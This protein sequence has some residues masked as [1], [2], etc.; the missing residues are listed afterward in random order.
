MTAGR[1]AAAA[2]LALSLLLP[3]GNGAAEL[4]DR[5]VASVN[6]DV[7]ALSDLRRAVAFNQALGARGSGR[8]LAVEVLEGLINRSLLRQEAARL[9]FV[10]VTDE[11]ASAETA[12]LRARLGSEEAYRDLLDRTGVTEEQLRRMLGERLLVERFVERKIGLYAR[13]SRDEAEAYFRDHPEE[14]KNKRFSEVQK[15]ITS[16]LSGQMVG[17][18]VDL[19]LADLRG[20]ADIRINPLQD[21]DGF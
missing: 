1:A 10:E 7:I 16:L 9:R 13:V 5:V 3:A 2:L 20:R 8:K 11:E 19:Y 17:Q 12:R 14:F 4:M 15:E 18:Q 6:N 21:R